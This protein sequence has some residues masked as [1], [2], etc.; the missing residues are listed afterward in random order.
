MLKRIFPLLTLLLLSACTQVSEQ[1]PLHT[2]SAT[3]PEYRQTDFQTY[4]QDT[5]TWLEQQRVFV[6]ADKQA[7]LDANTP[8]ELPPANGLPPRKGIL[9]VH[10]LGD[11]PFFFRDISQA[12][13]QQGFLVRTLLLP[14]H[15]SRPADL[16]LADADEW[17]AAVSHH[18]RLLQQQVD[19]VWLGGFS[20]GANLATSEAL[21]NDDV[22]GLLLFSPAIVP[23]SAMT[24]LLPVANLFSNW[25][26]QDSSD[27]NYT[28]YGS[29]TTNGATQYYYTTRQVRQQ[30]AKS[31]YKKPVL[32]ALSADDSVVD[33]EAVKTLFEQRFSNPDSKLFWFGETAAPADPRIKVLA[34]Q[35]PQLQISNFSHMSLLFAAN[36]PFYGRNGSHRVCENG[37]T[38]AAERLCPASNDLWYSNWG[39]QEA[40]KVHARLT[41]NPYFEELVS[42]MASVTSANL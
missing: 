6:S 9:L 21:S 36:N 23:E 22:S 29:L 35:L 1:S 17:Q 31:T 16:M 34:S 20:T 2:A 3:L 33:S 11:S 24:H 5:R 37:Q 27:G 39:Y 30:L 18:T 10:G 12:L 41:W 38:E 40:G 15:G 32:I 4:I 25:L 7:E 42:G 19:E 28:R 13:S 26:D 8:Y 14:G